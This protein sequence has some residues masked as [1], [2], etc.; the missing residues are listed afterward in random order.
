MQTHLNLLDNIN[1]E[2]VRNF[3][4]I[5]SDIAVAVNATHPD[6]TMFMDTK[7]LKPHSGIGPTDHR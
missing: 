7:A 4:A 6:S 3:G 1:G 5:Y 2:L